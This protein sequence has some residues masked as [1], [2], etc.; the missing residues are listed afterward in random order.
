MSVS[1]CVPTFGDLD[2]DGDL[3][4]VTGNLFGE[5]QCFLRQRQIWEEKNV[6]FNGIETDQMLPQR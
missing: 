2:A 4:M 3:D 5:V 6:L 1:D